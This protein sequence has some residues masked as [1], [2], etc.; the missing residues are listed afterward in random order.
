MISSDAKP[1]VTE[2]SA[3][4]PEVFCPRWTGLHP[5]VYQ[6]KVIAEAVHLC[7]VNLH[8]KEISELI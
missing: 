3:D 6:D 2:L 7:E 5:A 4:M 8:C 1:P